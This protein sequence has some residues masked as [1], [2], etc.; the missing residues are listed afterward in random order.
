[1]APKKTK[2]TSHLRWLLLLPIPVIW[3]LC[4]GAGWLDFLENRTTDWRFQFRGEI[5]S[6]AKVV[7]VDIDSQALSEI[8]GFPWSRVYF[9][10]VLQALVEKGDVKGI[11][12]DIVFS[13]N[14]VAEA[15][16]WKKR[17]EGNRELARYLSKNPP[18]VTA[19]SYAAPVD[20]DIN[21]RLVFRSLPRV[22]HLANPDEAEPPE[23]PVFRLSETD[24]RRTWSP[25]LVGL[26]D[27]LDGETRVVPAYAPSAIRT[28]LHMSVELARLHFGVKPEGVK[29]EPNHIDLVRDDGALVTRIPL[30]EQQMIEINWFSPW[31]AATHNPRISFSTVF[32]YAEMLNSDSEAERD[33][34]ERFF[35]QPDF[36]GA[37]VLIGPVDPLLQDLAVTPFDDIPVPKVGVHGNMVKTIVSGLY[38]QRLSPLANHGLTLGLTLL[39]SLFAAAGGA[40]GARTK[41]TAAL[42]MTTYVWLA[43]KL[44]ADHHLLLPMTAPLGAAFT[45]SFAAIIWQLIIEEKQ[46]GRIK[47]MFGAY[48]SPQLVER[49]VESGENPQLGGH[50]AEITAY[51]SDIQSFSSFS[52]KLGSGPL[53]DLMNEYLTAC[54]DIVQTQGGTLDKYI[55]DAVVAMYGAPLPLKDHAFRACVS[56]QLVHRKIAELRDKWRSEAGKWPEIVYNMQTRVGLNTGTCMI[57]NMG[58]RTR[59]N[60]TMMGDNVNLAARMESGAKSWGAY[61]MCTESTKLACEE[62]GGDRVIF[63]PLGRIVVKGRTQAVPIH[64]IGALKEYAT[65]EQ[66]ECY[67]IFEQGLAK[68]YARDWDGAI[69][70][71][72]QSAMFEPNQPG[73]TPGVSSNPSLV[74]IKITEQYKVEPPPADWD[75]VY[76]M[77]EK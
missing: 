56:T 1:M 41:L 57:G 28:Y 67:N 32:Q 48:V 18:V 65:A 30:I 5:G 52:E 34:A 54:T 39:V 15:I 35:A 9:A 29:I 68:H 21:G 69:A 50:D 16:D 23:T 62:H 66:L 71:F 14:G 12:V 61:T 76:V 3:S 70:L 19:A 43:F 36:K 22:L 55:G 58:S 64:E 40:R 13:E 7:Y 73:V 72:K 75:G 46:K 33:A 11:G 17:V 10:R 8:G 42:L 38:L 49:M 60:Y 20:R 51:F 45:T 4:A 26:I 44:F 2:L 24:S 74:Y 27:S 53:V 59:F 47:G 31:M 63:R 25:G 37:I 77:T 6:T